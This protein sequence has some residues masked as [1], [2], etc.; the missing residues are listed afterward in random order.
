MRNG[1]RAD[2]A[3]TRVYS[4]CHWSA[5]PGRE[6]TRNDTVKINLAAV[7]DYA[8]REMM[9]DP[10]GAP[11][12]ADLWRRFEHHLQQAVDITAQCLD[13]HMAHAH[14][15]F[16][17]LVLDLLCHGPIEK[18]EDASHGGVEFYN[19]CVDGAGLATVADS[20]AALEQ[21]LDQ[22]KRLT[23]QQ[24]MEHL[25]SNWAGPGGEHARVMMQNT[26]RYGQGGT[27]ADDHARRV[28]QSF[29]EVITAKSTPAGFRMIPGL[30][31]WANTLGMGETLG[32]TPNGRHAGAPIS[33]GANPHPGFRA[34]GAATAM[35]VAIAS[36]QPGYGNTAP[37]QLEFDPMVTRDEAAVNNIC[38]LIRTHF[39]LGGTQ[40][41]LNIMD[42]Q[43][44]LDAHADPSKYPD[45]VVRVTGF[46][47]YFASLSPEFRQLVVDR[48]VCS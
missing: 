8:L 28:A 11:N 26:P 43:R 24:L 36:V 7:F 35:A 18:G 25:E 10:G 3:R 40:I 6:Y 13:F 45:L 37:M 46:S 16:P 38:N 39:E 9:T 42:A 17:E 22:E 12:V 27:R 29:T 20:F 44:V 2:L 47:A 23:W 14:Q 1:Y 41:N 15:V 48:I 32:A 19:L 4:G 31:S 34:D 33:H 30:F 5:I 21:R